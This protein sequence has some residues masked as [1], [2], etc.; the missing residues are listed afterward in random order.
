M[1][2]SSFVG[3]TAVDFVAAQSLERAPTM[4]GANEDENF[5]NFSLGFVNKFVTF[6]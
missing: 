1:Q 4:I 3:T 5:K 2:N 6:I